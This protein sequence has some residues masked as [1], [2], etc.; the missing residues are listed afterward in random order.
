MLLLDIQQN[1]LW[2]CGM[3]IM[4]VSCVQMMCN[5]IFTLVSSP[6]R[7]VAAM[8]LLYAQL[9]IAA[10]AALILLICVIPIQVRTKFVLC[11][12]SCA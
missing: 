2:H 10:F 11:T 7:I 6:L 12:C 5:Q 9:G 8:F 3:K 4:Y 1:S